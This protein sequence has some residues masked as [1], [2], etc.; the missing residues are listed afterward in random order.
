[1]NS[2]NQNSFNIDQIND[3]LNHAS[4]AIQCGPKCQKMKTSL[5]L[6]QK[7]EQ[8]KMNL[9]TA[10]EQ[11]QEAAKNFY[12][13]VDGDNGYN[14]YIQKQLEE[15]VGMISG[16]LQKDFESAFLKAKQMVQTYNSIFMNFIHVEELMIGY[17]KENN[18]LENKLKNTSSDILT[19]DRKTY[20][21]NQSIDNLKLYY[22]ILK[23]IY[24]IIIAT[25]IFCVFLVPSNISI[26]KHFIILIFLGVLPF[27][28]YYFSKIIFFI[29]LNVTSILPK[30]VYKDKDY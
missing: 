23:Y 15:K 12:I 7:L 8:S 17:I 2:L 10:P 26:G 21:E 5:E 11:V 13:Y 22:T 29:Y 28:L 25:Y 19:N 3:F 9:L 20:Y 18:H 14:H 16:I 1:M 4:Q 27:I 6:E 30:N 24:L